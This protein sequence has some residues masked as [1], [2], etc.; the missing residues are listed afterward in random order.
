ME[1]AN[2][3]PLMK[4]AKPTSKQK[5][6]EITMFKLQYSGKEKIEKTLQQLWNQAYSE[7]LRD[8]DRMHGKI[9][10]SKT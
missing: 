6:I 5:A 4:D 3:P 7:G 10:N 8:M 1:S 9:D 2:S